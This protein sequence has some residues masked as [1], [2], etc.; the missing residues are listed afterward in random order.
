MITIIMICKHIYEQINKYC[1]NS[2]IN[3][4]ILNFILFYNS[5][6]ITLFLYIQVYD[7]DLIIEEC[8]VYTKSEIDNDSIPKHLIIF[9]KQLYLVLI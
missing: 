9:V 1:L 8:R 2:E 5:I 7:N 3:I 6:K 4:I